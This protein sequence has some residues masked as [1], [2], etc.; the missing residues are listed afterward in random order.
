MNHNWKSLV[1]NNRSWLS[2][3]NT[4]MIGC[5]ITND[6]H[7]ITLTIWPKAGEKN[8]NNSKLTIW[9]FTFTSILSIGNDCGAPALWE[10]V[11]STVVMHNTL[12]LRRKQSL[13]FNSDSCEKSRLNSRAYTPEG[14][15][16]MFQ[17]SGGHKMNRISNSSFTL[18]GGKMAHYFLLTFLRL[19][20]IA[21]PI[22]STQYN[23]K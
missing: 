11:C 4:Q 19:E 15:V 18:E 10:W 13:A 2:W 12:G 21:A 6:R 8:K 17:H 20:S 7:K 16:T 22:Q 1:W 9:S 23:Q 5:A 3:G 14:R